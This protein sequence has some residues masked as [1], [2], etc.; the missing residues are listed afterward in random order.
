[1]SQISPYRPPPSHCYRPTC[2][3]C[4]SLVDPTK[5]M[6]VNCGAPQHP[7][8]LS[9]ESSPVV[10]EITTMDDT[11]RRYILASEG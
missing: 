4:R 7:V 2:S 1:M 11:A 6:C 8:H 3:Y 5:T 9:G 10:I